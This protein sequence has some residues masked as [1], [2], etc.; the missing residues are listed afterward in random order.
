[1][2]FIWFIYL[3]IL[4]PWV[5]FKACCL[6]GHDQ[7]SFFFCYAN[8]C[9]SHWIFSVIK[10]GF[11]SVNRFGQEAPVLLIWLASESLQPRPRFTLI[12]YKESVSESVNRFEEDR[13]LFLSSPRNH[14]WVN[15]SFQAKKRFVLIFYKGS[16]VNQWIISCMTEKE[17]VLES[18]V[19]LAKTEICSDL[20]Q[21]INFDW[22][23]V[24]SCTGKQFWS[25][26][27]I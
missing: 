5:P 20:V 9:L 13:D 17:S 21:G 27:I 15:E 23:S 8:H 24:L 14:F 10:A 22:K 2:L 11:E 7:D 19:L 1:M 18:F 4:H 12:L 25:H 26:W 3:F 16:C 6:F